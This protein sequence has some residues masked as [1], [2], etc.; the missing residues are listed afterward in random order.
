MRTFGAVLLA[1]AASAS[2]TDCAVS[3]YQTMIQSLFQGFQDDPTAT[4]TECYTKTGVYNSKLGQFFSAFTEFSI[5]DWAA[6]LYVGSE[7]M[8][9]ATDIFTYCQTTNLAK[10]FAIRTNSISGFFDLA[11]T[12]GVAYFKEYRQP[13]GDNNPLFDAIGGVT[14]TDYTCAQSMNYVGQTIKYAFVYEVADTNF[15]DQLQ[16]NLVDELFQ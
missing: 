15:V 3:E 4:D 1:T 12:I 16:Q 11:A 7:L 2:V 14:S 5:D 9:A 8:V 10:Q 13:S 6:P